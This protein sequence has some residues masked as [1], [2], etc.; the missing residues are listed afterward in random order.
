M[1][2]QCLS[3]GLNVSGIP[4]GAVDLDP[5]PISDFSKNKQITANVS[6]LA[7]Y[8]DST[9]ISSITSIPAILANIKIHNPV[10]PSN[11]SPKQI[12]FILSILFISATLQILTILKIYA[13]LFIPAILHIL[14]ILNSRQSCPI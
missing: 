11:S 13:I 1:V 10:H 14:T 2:D 8:S 6:D 5:G 12:L 4:R 7:V 9:K 3:S